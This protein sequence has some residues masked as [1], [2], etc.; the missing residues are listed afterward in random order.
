M[1][2]K[3]LKITYQDGREEIVKAL[4]R[5]Q[6]M[7]EEHL[8]G[9]NS[10][11]AITATFYL[12]WASLIVAKKET[13]DYETWLNHVDDVEDYEDTPPDPTPADPSADISSGSASVQDS[14]TSR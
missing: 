8:K 6:V 14:L 9:Y 13:L 3:S 7:T 12:G 2:S 11:N 5:A 4:P 10:T 1:A